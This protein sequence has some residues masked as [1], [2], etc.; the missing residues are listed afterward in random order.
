MFVLT[1]VQE[2]RQEQRGYE[3]KCYSQNSLATRSVQV[4]RYLAFVELFADNRAPF[5]CSPGRV[6]LYAAWL[7]RTLTYRSVV[8][9]LSGLNYFLRKSGLKGIQYDDYVVSAT[10]KGIRREKGDAPRRAPPILPYMLLRMFGGL[11]GNQGHVAWRAAV[12]CSFRGLLRKAQVTESEASLKRSDFKFFDWGMIMRVKRTKTI[13]YG[14]RQLDIPVARCPNRELCAVHWVERHFRETP[15]GGEDMAFRTPRGIRGSKA[16][17]YREYQDM[18]RIFAGQA[19]LGGGD[20][21]S[22]S[23]RRGGCTYLAMCGAT[24]EEIKCRGDWASETVYA[25]LSTPIQT[26]ILNDIRVASVLAGVD[27]R[28]E[29]GL[30]AGPD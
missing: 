9:Y 28:D 2:L 6:A 22:H 16:L 11:T 1:G 3:G 23:L 14:E 29:G 25:Y 21:T 24:I 30:E 15:A 5:P 17:T 18:L 4:K 8:N 26:R 7:A 12:L 19:G 20:F 13:Q 10:L 27:G